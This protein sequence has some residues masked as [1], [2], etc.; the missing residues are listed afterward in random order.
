MRLQEGELLALLAAVL[1]CAGVAWPGEIAPRSALATV[2]FVLAAG[3]LGCVL[4]PSP[5]GP[6]GASVAVALGTL[7]LS[8]PLSSEH[9]AWKRA[10]PVAVAGV[11]AGVCGARLQSTVARRIACA[12]LLAGGAYVV[13]RGFH[14]WLFGFRAL[15]EAIEADVTFDAAERKLML[16]RIAL[17][18]PWAPFSLPGLLGGYLCMLVPIAAGLGLDPGVPAPRRR[19]ALVLATLA[20]GLLVVAMSL[21]ALA[22]AAASLGVAMV[23]RS[24][25]RARLALASILAAIILAAGVLATYR[26]HTET[27]ARSSVALRLSNWKAALCV[28]RLAPLTGVGPGSFGY[29]YPRFIEAGGNNTQHAHSLVMR[30][31]AE[32]GLL[33]GGSVIAVLGVAFFLLLRVRSTAILDGG[34]VI[35]AMAGLFHGLVD[36]D[37]D[38]ESLALFTPFIT[39]LALGAAPAGV[40]KGSRLRG[41]V[42]TLPM[43]L[44]IMPYVAHTR[45]R[46]AI[47]AG[48]DL[49]RR[50][51]KDEAIL[52]YRQ[53]LLVDRDSSCLRLL[54]AEALLDTGRPADAVRLLEE[55]RALSPDRGVVR[56]VLAV[57]YASVGRTA[58][59]QEEARAALRLIPWDQAAR[60]TYERLIGPPRSR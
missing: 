55:A 60:G 23:V 35:A 16:D 57:A 37:F 30:S 47:E 14:Q 40:R 10:I 36:I 12:I 33:G 46:V 8:V 3:A 52:R 51:E 26:A 29:F 49:L 7:L 17:G 22:S 39:G 9:D 24:R 43:L 50:G 45:S 19:I 1:V 13:F 2:P 21:G 18:R 31:L 42:A 6:L 54:A 11:S 48:G 59:A 38:Q 32:T 44:C 25:G 41:A 58:D 27:F 15:R 4:H 28:W 5:A 34:L 20:G 56:Q 53:G